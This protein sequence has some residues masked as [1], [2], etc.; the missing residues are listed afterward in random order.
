MVNNVEES[1]II[2]FLY[3]EMSEEETLEFQKLIDQN[4]N[5]KSKVDEVSGVKSVMRSVPDEEVFVPSFVL[6]NTEKVSNSYWLSQPVRWVSS[7]AAGLTLILVFAYLME[8][9]VSNNEQGLMIGFGIQPVDQVE[10]GESLTKE[11]IQSWMSEVLE[12][13]DGQND[14][15]LERFASHV[16]DELKRQNASNEK[17]INELSKKYTGETNQLMK[18]YVDQVGNDNKELIEN[19]FKVSTE[20]QQQYVKSVMADFNKFYQR[21]REYDLQ[22]M[23][24]SM[25]LMNNKHEVQQIEQNTLL[26]NLYQMV[27][28][29]SK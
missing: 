22:V 12:S 2:D 21:Q 23:E 16:N 8:L 4:P 3:G 17:A 14:L 5:L 15:K 6:N 26:A 29:Q 13:Y 19:F 28:T 27:N 11:E 25:D 9:R 10:K 1:K 7:I 18:A 20:T 24:A